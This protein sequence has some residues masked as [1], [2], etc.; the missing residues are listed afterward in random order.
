MSYGI[1]K[2][3]LAAESCFWT[4]QRLNGTQLLGPGLAETPKFLNTITVDSSVS[5]LMVH[6]MDPNG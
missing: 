5:F 3:N 6:Y 4:E 2:I 1:L